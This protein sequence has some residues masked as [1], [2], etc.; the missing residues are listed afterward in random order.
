MA[1]AGIRGGQVIGATD[2]EGGFPVASEYSTEQVVA[3]IYH[4]LGLPLDLVVQAN[5]GRPVR[6]LESEPIREWA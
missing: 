2:E 6:L 3:T 5:D 1:G 4:K